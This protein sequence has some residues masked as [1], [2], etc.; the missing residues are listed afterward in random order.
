M[1]KIQ[2][3]SVNRLITSFNF[4][5]G[6][7]EKK[8]LLLNIIFF[9]QFDKYLFCVLV[10]LPYLQADKH[11]SLQFH[12]VRRFGNKICYKFSCHVLISH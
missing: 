8:L 6:L 7:S 1:A 3:M 12:V 10:L 5:I 11:L 9:L 4:I 2:I